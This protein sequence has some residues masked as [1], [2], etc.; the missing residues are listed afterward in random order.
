MIHDFLNVSRLEQGGMNI[1]KSAIDITE[2]INQVIEEGRLLSPLHTFEFQCQKAIMVYADGDKIELVLT[3]LISNAIKY[4]PRGGRITVSCTKVNEKIRIAVTDEGIGI[5][6]DDQKQLFKRF[7]RVKDTDKNITGFGIGLYLTAEIL[8]IH[9]AEITVKS[10][11]GQGSE[12]SFLLDT[13]DV[14]N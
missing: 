12:F 7:Y 6:P 14:N 9:N 1:E 13:I 10:E 5:H 2:I 4:A 3:N 11:P 8:R